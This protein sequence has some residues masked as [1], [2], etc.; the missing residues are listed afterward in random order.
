MKPKSGETEVIYIDTEPTEQS[1]K[2]AWA[3]KWSLYKLTKEEIL[4]MAEAQGFACASCGE[5]AKGIEYRLCVDHNHTTNEIRGLLC[6]GCNTAAGWL[7]DSPEKAELL[8]NYLR[9]AGTGKVIPFTHL[10]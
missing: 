9:N 1:L 5:D 10:D 8:A 6:A 4:E 7:N 3:Q 2:N